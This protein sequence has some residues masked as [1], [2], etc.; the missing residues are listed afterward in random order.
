[1]PTNSKNAIP[2]LLDPRSL[3]IVMLAATQDGFIKDLIPDGGGK[4]NLKK[5]F[6]RLGLT[7]DIL[8]DFINRAKA[9]DPAKVQAAFLQM[10][11]LMKTVFA[12]D[13]QPPDC[14]DTVTLQNFVSAAND[15]STAVASFHKALVDRK[16]GK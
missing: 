12:D 1:M 11:S 16:K 9:K 2:K 6:G 4:P 5:N 15:S 13:Y 8:N 7:D 14:P 3:A 10:N